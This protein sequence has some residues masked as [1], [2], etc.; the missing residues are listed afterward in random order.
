MQTIG[1]PPLQKMPCLK[2]H[3]ENI[4]TTVSAKLNELYPTDKAIGYKP[5]EVRGA[6][7]IIQPM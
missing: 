1:L 6:F 4:D 2:S 3:G 5:G 7:T